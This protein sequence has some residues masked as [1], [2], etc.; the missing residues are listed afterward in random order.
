MPRKQTLAQK[1][2]SVRR[3]VGYIKKDATVKGGGIYTAVSHD[4]VTAQ[5]R[6]SLIKHCLIISPPSV[7]SSQVVDTGAVTG[8]GTPIIRY[9]AKY[10][11]SLMSGDGESL[12]SI[13]E[14]HANDYGDKAP[15]KAM[16]Y[17]TKYFMLKMFNL[18]TGDEEEGRLAMAGQGKII[19]TAQYARLQNLVGQIAD[20]GGEFHEPEY[21]EYL[22]SRGLVGKTMYD[23]TQGIYPIAIAVL[24]KK[25]IAALQK[26]LA[27][28][29][30][31]GDG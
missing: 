30:E 19:D 14:A 7:V 20:A 29:K 24:Q 10:E 27:K 1:I 18:E 21:I 13:I 22:N 4:A 5:I 15:G 25:A 3:E 11:I 26:K 16:S 28:V 17:A 9:E 23:I 6:N 31:N 12:T 2:N 8:G